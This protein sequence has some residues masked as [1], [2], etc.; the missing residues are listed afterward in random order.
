MSPPLLPTQGPDEPAAGPP[1]PQEPIARQSGQLEL[2][3]VA[4]RIHRERIMLLGWGRAILLQFA[5]PLVAAGVA[6]HSHFGSSPSENRRRLLRTVEAMLDLTFGDSERAGRTA[7]RIDGIH[8]RVVGRLPTATGPFEVETPYAARM[9]ELLAW[10]YATMLDSS[11]LVYQLFIGPLTPDEQDRYCAESQ[12]AGPLLGLPSTM[13]PASRADLDTY[14]NEMYSSGHLTVGATAHHLMQ[15]LLGAKPLWFVTGPLLDL[16]HWPTVGLLPPAI[17]EA[18]G[19]PW[20]PVR[21][22]SL[23]QAARTSRLIVP[24]LPSWLRD[25]PIARQALRRAAPVTVGDRRPTW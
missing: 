15:V 19:L 5:H 4:W 25:W 3:R 16:L 9:P 1:T 10:V 14:M 7:R 22:A 21:A 12:T 17:R 2:S 20:G 13:I 8:G 18:Y 11:L 24:R 6:E 23:Q